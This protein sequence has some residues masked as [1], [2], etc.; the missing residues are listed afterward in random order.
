MVHV[1]TT[2]TIGGVP[3]RVFGAQPVTPEATGAAG[4][5]MARTVRPS[6]SPGEA[7]GAGTGERQVVVDT[8]KWRTHTFDSDFQNNV[9]V[10]GV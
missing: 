6:A 2:M 7:L 5:F 1:V 9:A 4:A 3:G 8:A 10:K